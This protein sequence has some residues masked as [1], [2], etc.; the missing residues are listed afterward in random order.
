MKTGKTLVE[1]AT[2]IQRQAA[3]KRDFVVDTSGVEALVVDGRV[4]LQFGPHLMPLNPLAHD[5]V[6]ARLEI[7]RA[8]YGKMLADAPDLLAKNVNTWLHQEPEKRMVRTLDG[9]VRAFLSDKYRPLENVDLAEAAL[10]ALQGMGVEVLSCE[11]TEKRLYLKAYDRS[12]LRDIP[13][14]RSMGDGTHTIFD[15]VCPV[16]CLSNSEVGAGATSIESGF[17]TRACTNTAFFGERSMRRYHVGGKHE[18]TTGFEELLSDKTKRLTDA[19]VWA[20]IGDVLKGAFEAARFDARLAVMVGKAELKITGSVEKVVDVTA[21]RF[22]LADGERNSV[23][24][25]LIEGGDLSQYGMMNAVTR[26]AQDVEDYDRATEFER[27]GGKVID[28]AANEW[29]ALAAAA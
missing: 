14:G 1:L 22:G 19:A 12:L 17:Y 6:A 29:Q 4:D 11:L 20:Q 28:L 16:V 3:T 15:T 25:H 7:P 26:T 9:Q 13:S 5:Q 23:L 2:E 8:Y 27:L 18:L 21:K 10:P 24:K